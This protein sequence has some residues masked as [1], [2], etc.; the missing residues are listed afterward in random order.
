[1]EL[2]RPIEPLLAELR[3][4]SVCSLVIDVVVT[5]GF[6]SIGRTVLHDQ[7]VCFDFAVSKRGRITLFHVKSSQLGKIHKLLNTSEHKG[8]PHPDP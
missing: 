2:L 8:Y 4:G 5:N 3:D 1:M 6:Q 7:L